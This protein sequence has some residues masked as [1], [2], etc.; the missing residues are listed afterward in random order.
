SMVDDRVLEVI[1]SRTNIRFVLTCPIFVGGQVTG[2]IA[3]H[4]PRPMSEA[5]QRSCE[6][7]AREAALTLENAHLSETLR[8]QVEELQRSRRLIT[9]AEERQRREIAELLHGR[10]QTS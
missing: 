2:A 7:F 9:A 5:Q 8:Q 3:Y 4:L 6:A 1:S 10:V